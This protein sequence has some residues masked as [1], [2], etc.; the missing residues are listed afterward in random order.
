MILH[1]D[2]IEPDLL[3]ELRERDRPLGIR[4]AGRDEAPEQQVV[5]VVSHHPESISPT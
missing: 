4:G 3:G 5:A 2:Q 1:A